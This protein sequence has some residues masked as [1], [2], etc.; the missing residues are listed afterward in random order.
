LKP[1][2]PI[3]K[4]KIVN[5]S[6]SSYPPVKRKELKICWQDEHCMMW[7]YIHLFVPLD[8]NRVVKKKPTI[9][10]SSFFKVSTLHVAPNIYK[11]SQP[12]PMCYIY[13]FTFIEHFIYLFWIRGNFH[14]L[15]SVLCGSRWTIKTPA[16]PGSYKKYTS[17][18]ELE[19]CYAYF[20]LFVITPCLREYLYRTRYLTWES[21]GKFWKYM[22]KKLSP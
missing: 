18:L 5:L 9:F 10:N 7:L 20:K 6:L 4:K 22:I 1:I 8:L 2:P 14:F 17:W 16:V 12:N 11:T 13:G 3:I 19:I 15:K 21:L